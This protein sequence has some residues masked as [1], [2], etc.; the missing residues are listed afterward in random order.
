MLSVVVLSE[1]EPP[2][3]SLAEW[4]R[5]SST[6]PLYLVLSILCSSLTSFPDLAGGKRDA[7]T[8]MLHCGDDLDLCYM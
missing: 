3:K 5:L 4:N 2:P 7:T 8:T 1:G 6:I